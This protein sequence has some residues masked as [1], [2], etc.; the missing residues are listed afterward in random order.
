MH[1]IISY[2]IANSYKDHY[3][4]HTIGLSPASYKN[5]KYKPKYTKTIKCKQRKQIHLKLQNMWLHSRYI[6]LRTCILNIW[7]HYLK[8]LKQRKIGRNST[9]KHFITMYKYTMTIHLCKSTFF[10]EYCST[11]KLLLQERIL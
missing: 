3:N 10:K 11:A 7:Q 4:K 5:T 9:A 6:M 8:W 1:V 2:C